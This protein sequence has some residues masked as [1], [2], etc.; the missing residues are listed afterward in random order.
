MDREEKK[1]FSYLEN[2]EDNLFSREEQTVIYQIALLADLS[3]Q[4]PEMEMKSIL[5]KLERTL[6]KLDEPPEE[7]LEADS[8]EMEQEI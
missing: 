1:L 2:R 6:G 3:E 8:D 5:Y 4:F 7:E